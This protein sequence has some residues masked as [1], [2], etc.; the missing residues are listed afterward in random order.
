MTTWFDTVRDLTLQLVRWPSVTNS[1][2]ERAWGQH[3]HALLA[4]TPYFRAHPEHLRLQPTT[5]DRYERFNVF[6]FVQ[7]NGSQTVVLAGHYDVVSIDNYGS[8]APYANDPEALLPRLI[9]ELSASGHSEADQCALRDLQSGN[10]MPGRGALDMKCG[11][12]AGIAVLLHFAA[13]PNR[14]GNLLLIATPDE[15]EGSHG[16]RSAAL[17]LPTLRREWNLDLLAGINLDA[18]SDRGDGSEG[19]AIFLGTVGKF[20]PSV[21]VVGSETHAGYPFDGINPN[22]LAAAITQRIECNVRLCDEA[23]GEVAPPPVSLKQTDLKGYYDVTTPGTAWCYFNYLTHGK[24]AALVLALFVD[25]VQA[26]L[27]AVLAAQH[28]LAQEYAARTGNGTTAPWQATV[29][30]FA[31]LRTQALAAGGDAAQHALDSLTANLLDDTS[32]DAPTFS[33]RIIEVL[34][35]NS[36]L[37]GPA[38]VVGFGSLHYPHSLIIGTTPA[39]ARLLA[40]AETETTRLAAERDI[41]LRV[42]PF[43]T[44]ISDMSFLGSA[45]M[46]E[47]IASVAE[48]TPLWGSRLR[49]DYAAV[50]TLAVPVVNIG[51][52]GRD[53]HQRNERVFMPYSFEVVPELIWRIARAVL[54][55]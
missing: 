52:W 19:Q 6:A 9:A 1:P 26:A 3:L 34:W 20:L 16:M 2:D 4:Q 13:Q 7:G 21:F 43:F 22:L 10:Y 24:P 23:Q 46:S 47:D 17:H 50:R 37:S 14:Q 40:I 53:Y 29:M 27:D 18:T 8:L 5:D 28:T 25:E 33:R 39:Q 45:M 11:L 51:A 12:A 55:G 38:A 15:E 44:G 54:E 30:T 35:A 49:F 31:E 36:G 48:N 42:R 41:S 32:V